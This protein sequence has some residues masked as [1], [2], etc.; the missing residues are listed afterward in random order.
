MA[1]SSV[2]AAKRNRPTGKARRRSGALLH[3][4]VD[5]FRSGLHRLRRLSLDFRPSGQ[6]TSPVGSFGR[7]LDLSA[8][9]SEIT[10]MH[11]R[12]DLD[13]SELRSGTVSEK[14]V[15]DLPEFYDVE[16][17]DAKHVFGD[18]VK[19][20]DADRIFTDS[21]KRAGA[22]HIFIDSAK[23]ADAD[24]DAE[25]IFS[26]SVERADAE[27]I[28]TDSVKS[29]DADH[30][31]TDSA[32][33][34][35]ADHIFTDSVKRAD[36]EQ[37]FSVSFER[38]DAEHV[39]ADSAKR[40]DAEEDFS[41]N[42]DRADAGQKFAGNEEMA[43]P[44][45]APNFSLRDSPE[46]FVTSLCPSLQLLS[47][48]ADLDPVAGFDVTPRTSTF[49]RGCGFY[50]T[51]S[52][53][54]RSDTLP[55]APLPFDSQCPPQLVPPIQF[56][57][58][59]DTGHSLAVSEERTDADQN[60]AVCKYQRALPPT[61]SF[62]FR[63]WNGSNQR[64]LRERG[65]PD[66]SPRLPEPPGVFV[67]VKCCTPATSSPPPTAALRS[68]APSSS[69]AV[70]SHAEL[71]LACI[72]VSPIRPVRP[73]SASLTDGGR[74][75]T[76]S[77][78]TSTKTCMLED[79]P[80][81]YPA[82]SSSGGEGDEDLCRPQ[83]HAS[84]GCLS[85]PCTPQAEAKTTCSGCER[86]TSSPFP[87]LLGTEGD[88]LQT[89]LPP[90]VSAGSGVD[91]SR[92]TDLVPLSPI[93]PCGSSCDIASLANEI[94]SLSDSAYSPKDSVR[95]SS[96]S[97]DDFSDDSDDSGDIDGSDTDDSDNVGDSDNTDGAYND[98][99]GSNAE[100]SYLP[101]FQTPI[102]PAKHGSPVREFRKFHFSTSS[103]SSQQP[104]SL[105]D[106]SSP[107][108]PPPIPPARKRSRVMCRLVRVRRRLFARQQN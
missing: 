17:A 22:D 87:W 73:A 60:L 83:L 51:S 78:R 99:V 105:A 9:L 89:G 63:R 81:S 21:V 74:V 8:S 61:P 25:Q 10:S 24:H 56:A 93:Q 11:F 35:D 97:V 75:F 96:G 19:R 62:S 106:I 64:P 2:C 33:R 58:T 53:L 76:T 47:E 16:K 69:D 14:R 6:Q 20:A 37:I 38:A 55:T 29:A 42:V 44:P 68:A 72:T 13:P 15:E 1:N 28:F 94:V 26:V 59:S 39:F 108:P 92:F 104:C 71:C 80:T 4:V 23:R 40:A 88:A 98:S 90:V 103:R 48:A 32:K 66:D 30:I 67:Q 41:I 85:L 18:S 49:R 101:C 70:G 45:T 5:S 86:K 52:P 27:H 82:A 100:L 7:G 107:S 31:F 95:C 54:S 57:P 46:K 77:S 65:P 34:A 43:A 84:A 79:T 36:A 50:C 91:Q 3:S 102:Q 12:R